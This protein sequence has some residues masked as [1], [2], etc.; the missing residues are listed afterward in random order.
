MGLCQ[1]DGGTAGTSKDQSQP[2]MFM[3]KKYFQI[4]LGKKR[5]KKTCEN[6]I[7]LCTICQLAVKK[8]L[9]RSSANILFNH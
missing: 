7:W 4:I 3:R 1:G 5:K 9:L 6:C 2:G 8:D